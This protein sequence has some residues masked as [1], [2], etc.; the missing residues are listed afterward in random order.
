MLEVKEI[1]VY[2]GAIH[3][4]KK[5]SSSVEQGSIVTL[6]RANGAGKTTT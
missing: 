5:L 6:I 4:L 1:E 3:A 2:N